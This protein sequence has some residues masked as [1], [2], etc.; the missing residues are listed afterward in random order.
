LQSAVEQNTLGSAR[1]IRKG[2]SWYPHFPAELSHTDIMLVS[3][4]FLV[5]PQCHSS[6]FGVTGSARIRWSESSAGV[7]SDK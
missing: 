3:I 6:F 5:V 1:G 7:I 2:S 4:R